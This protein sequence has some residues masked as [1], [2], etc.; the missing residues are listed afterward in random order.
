MPLTPNTIKES[1]TKFLDS[2]KIQRVGGIFNGDSPVILS[3]DTERW[4]KYRNQ[5]EKPI[6]DF[7]LSKFQQELEEIREEIEKWSDMAGHHGVDANSVYNAIMKI[8][9]THIE[10]LNT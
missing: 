8:L 7:F 5:I 6:A 1:F 3:E 10:K 2:I 9:S 4:L